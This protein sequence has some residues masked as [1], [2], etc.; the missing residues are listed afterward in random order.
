[1]F[2]FRRNFFS[3]VELKRTHLYLPIFAMLL[4]MSNI[5]TNIFAQRLV[6]FD[7]MGFAFTVG[8]G[9]FIFP[10]SFFIIDTV[11]EYYGFKIATAMI[12]FNVI[13]LGFCTLCFFYTMQIQPSN[14]LVNEHYKSIIIPFYRAF[15]ATACSV[16]TA[17]LLNCYL[18]ARLKIF[19]KGKKM[20]LRLMLATTFAELFY[21]FVWVSVDML[22]NV[23]LQ[24]FS[25]IIGSNF[26][27][28][29]VFQAISMPFTWLIVNYLIRIDN[30]SNIVVGS[31]FIKKD[32]ANG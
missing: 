32:K 8:G 5:G 10:I 13:A 11:T 1:M 7:I 18:I 26:V 21:S 12:F 27:V 6:S 2:L 30:S 9:I 29:I 25:T 28:K 17:Y 31:P 4:I 19:F 20:F 16:L 23:T 22:G 14:S 3:D 15:F 24:Q